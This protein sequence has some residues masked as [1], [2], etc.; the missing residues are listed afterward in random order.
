MCSCLPV[1]SGRP[2]CCQGRVRVPFV[3]CHGVGAQLRFR[4]NPRGQNVRADRPGRDRS[5]DPGVI[6]RR[7][8][9]VIG[10]W[11]PPQR[12]D[13]ACSPLR[14]RREEGRRFFRN[15]RSIR[16]VWFF[17]AAE[18][19]PPR[20]PRP[21]SGSEFGFSS[22]QRFTQ[23]PSVPSFTPVARATSAIGRPDSVTSLTPSRRN[24]SVN[25]RRTCFDPTLDSS[26]QTS[27]PRCRCPPRGVKSVASRDVVCDRSVDVRGVVM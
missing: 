1:R 8:I 24:S 26:P 10:S 20:S 25:F 7:H 18:P 23:L 2:G 16:S 6:S 19:T 17:A 5:A 12:S 3:L 14:L 9:I 13:G 4:H 15:S 21:N 11:P 22:R 27:D